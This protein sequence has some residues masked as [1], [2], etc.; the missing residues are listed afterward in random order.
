MNDIYLYNTYVFLNNMFYIISHYN[1]SYFSF[2]IQ[3]NIKINDN[4]KR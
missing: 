4:N 1:E 2:F 3:V